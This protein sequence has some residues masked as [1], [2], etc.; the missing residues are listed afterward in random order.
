[1]FSAAKIATPTSQQPC[2]KL[3]IGGHWVDAAS[4][5]AIDVIDPSTEEP[6]ASVAAGGA[7]DVDL[8]VSAARAALDSPQ[9]RDLTPAARARLMMKLADLIE[10]DSEELARIDSRNVGMPL[11]LARAV[12][13]AVIEEL[14][15]N[16]GWCMR[17]NGETLGVGIPG[18]T[19]AYTLREPIG[20]VAAIVPW[21]FPLVT[22]VV[23]VAPAL[24]A[25]CTIVLKPAEETPLSALKLGELALEAGFPPGVLNIVTGSGHQ[26]GDALAR[27]PGVNKVTVTGSTETGR[28]VIAAAAGNFKRVTLELGGKSPMLILNDADVPKAI[29]AAARSIFTNAGQVCSAGSRLYAE[30]DVYPKIVEGIL[31]IARS[32]YLSAWDDPKATMGPLI[33]ARHL[34]RVSGYVESATEQGTEVL[35]GGK[36]VGSRG[37]FYAPTVIAAKSN[38]SRVCQEEIFGPVLVVQPVSDVDEMLAR[39]NDNAFGLTAFI[40]TRDIILGQ[41]LAHRLQAGSVSINTGVVA[42]PNVPFGGY[43][44]SGWGRERGREGLDAY[45]QTKS[46][47]YS[48]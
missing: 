16:A 17:I 44:Q 37:Y 41:R 40:W 29:E 34:K 15:Y 31:A 4:R 35:T 42:G 30:A 18:K 43:K 14:R 7:E 21:N 26:A 36:R 13:P 24:A 46:V 5:K 28:S 47:G 25:G 32:H 2:G 6:W 1:M 12:V 3:L 48:L 38:S 39:A 23:K 8:A 27:H 20:V 9:W 22:A 11:A 33:S 19:H 45:L 10:R